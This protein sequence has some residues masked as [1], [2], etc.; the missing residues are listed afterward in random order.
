DQL[1]SLPDDP[2]VLFMRAAAK[3]AGPRQADVADTVPASRTGFS[4][5]G[6]QT[7]TPPIPAELQDHPRYE[8]GTF[9]GGGGMGTVFLAEHGLVERR[10]AVKVI[11]K[12]YL[13]RAGAVERFRQ[14]VKAAARLA[15]PNIVTAYDADQAGD[16]HFL[17]MEF[18][19]GESLD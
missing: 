3:P 16:V 9:L 17:V 10:V 1:E 15:H 8:M 2:L 7:T 12:D 4:A 5:P 19:P 14:E 18:V 6:S 13:A 11:R